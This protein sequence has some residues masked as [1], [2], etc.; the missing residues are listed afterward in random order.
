M[1]TLAILITTLT[2]IVV[3]TNMLAQWLIS[4][5]KLEFAYPLLML[6]Y[7]MYITIETILAFNDPTQISI[8]LFNIVNVWAFSMAFKGMRRLQKEKQGV[9]QSQ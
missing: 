6:V 7:S 4:R 9:L 1:T 5:G 2:L 3:P 8:L